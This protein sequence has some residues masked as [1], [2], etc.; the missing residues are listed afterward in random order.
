MSSASPRCYA[1][2]RRGMCAVY[3]VLPCKFAPVTTLSASLGTSAWAAACSHACI[4]QQSRRG[5]DCRALG[6]RIL[7]TFCNCPSA[8]DQPKARDPCYG[9]GWACGRHG[10]GRVFGSCLM[11][12]QWRE[13]FEVQWYAVQLGQSIYAQAHSR[14][15]SERACQAWSFHRSRR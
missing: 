10:F 11:R 15:C 12:A 13:N 2:S 8:R 14:L 9:A 3:T 1:W 5:V 7:G 4:W 6:H